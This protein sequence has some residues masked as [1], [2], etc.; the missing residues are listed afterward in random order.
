MRKFVAIL[1]CLLLLAGCKG[2][3]KTVATEP[4]AHHHPEW[5]YNSVVYEV[6]VRQFSQEGTL[7]AVQKNL[8]RLKRLGVDV[9]WL[10][11]I[12]PIGKEEH[13]G[14]L[15]SYYAISDYTK[16]NPEFGTMEDF[17]NLVKA[18]H[19]QGF[20]L[21]LDW[22]ANHTSPDH[23]WMTGKPADFYERDSLGKAKF[24]YD[25]ND[26]RSLNYANREVWKAQDEC[27]R[28]WMEKG[29]DGFRCDVAGEVP[30]EFWRG[31][32]PK[33]KKDYP[34]M[35]LL[36]EA[37]KAD[38]ADPDSTF[39]ATYAWK[40][41]HILND[42]AQGKK[43][44]SAIKEYV[45]S[46]AKEFLPTAFRLMFTS[47][48]DENSWNGSEFERMGDAAPV[49]QVLCFTL[50]KGQPLVYTGQEVGLTRRLEFFEKD[51][52]TDWTDNKH[53]EFFKKL[54]A[55][56]HANPKA[57]SAGE[58]GADIKYLS[59]GDNENILAFSREKEGNDVIVVANLSKEPASAKITLTGEYKDAFSE[60]SL[61]GEQEF[62]LG[63][64]EYRLLSKKSIL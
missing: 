19:E 26:T 46:D 52:V 14:T 38:I 21:I 10:M 36:A 31:I 11:P 4:A 41:H 45:A 33:M 3:P 62:K 50:P 51:P 59:V 48:H 49:M 1:S 44:A 28:F 58:K 23:V 7:A 64:W 8:P 24:D 61:T 39:D 29:I 55:F 5:A 17:E 2:K 27:M 18:A 43:K 12:Y 47:N 56:R 40:L 53:T 37:E 6:N 25:W 34:E 30:S 54:I 9:L 16:V 42:V 35:Y 32:L 20:K 57:L 15:G 22:V 13:K 60:Q 63:A